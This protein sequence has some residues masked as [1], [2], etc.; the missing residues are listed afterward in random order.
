MNF[1]LLMIYPAYLLFESFFTWKLVRLSTHHWRLSR[2][3]VRT[4]TTSCQPPIASSFAY[5]SPSISLLSPH[6][7]TCLLQRLYPPCLL[8]EATSTISPPPS[9]PLCER[10]TFPTWH[11][12]CTEALQGRRVLYRTEMQSTLGNLFNAEGKADRIQRF[13]E[14][15]ASMLAIC[16]IW[17]MSMTH[18]SKNRNSQLTLNQKKNSQFWS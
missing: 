6:F 11:T 4:D 16:S 3:C 17:S 8:L 10:R 14:I 12:T 18:C 1:L 9:L 13:D 15:L 2:T 5:L 7:P